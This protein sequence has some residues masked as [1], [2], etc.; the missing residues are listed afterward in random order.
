MDPDSYYN[1][2]DSNVVILAEIGQGLL[3]VLVYSERNNIAHV[4]V[5]TETALTRWYNRIPEA[6]WFWPQCLGRITDSSYL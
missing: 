5:M 3:T 2:R 4:G 1:S 6:P